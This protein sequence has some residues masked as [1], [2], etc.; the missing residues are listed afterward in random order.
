MFKANMFTNS[1]NSKTSETNRLLINL[2]DKVNLKKSDIYVA[3]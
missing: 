3:L 1:E 2:S